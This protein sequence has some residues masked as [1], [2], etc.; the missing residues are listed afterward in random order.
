MKILYSSPFVFVFMYTL[1]THSFICTSFK[2]L[3]RIPSVQ[4]FKI[5]YSS[6]ST[7]FGLY[8]GYFG[9]FV[10][11]PFKWLQKD[12]RDPSLAISNAPSYSQ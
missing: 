8:K 5:T 6:F 12:T 2:A 3:K 1:H 11:D 10:K 4:T 7:K 9:H